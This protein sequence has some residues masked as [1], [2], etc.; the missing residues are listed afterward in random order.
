MQQTLVK[1]GEA[2]AWMRNLLAVVTGLA[3]G[4]LGLTGRTGFILFLL[5]NVIASFVLLGKLRTLSDFFP[6]RLAL[7]MEGVSGSV[8]VCIKHSS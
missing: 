7:F 1:N 6:S 2:L 8:M 3:A 5:V 4:T